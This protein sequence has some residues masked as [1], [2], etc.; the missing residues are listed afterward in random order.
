MNKKMMIYSGTSILYFVWI[1]VIHMSNSERETFNVIKLV[2][3][4][5]GH[6]LVDIISPSGRFCAFDYRCETLIWNRFWF[7]KS[8]SHWDA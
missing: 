6:V 3:Y 8:N 2:F 7:G 1:N 4:L 5:Y